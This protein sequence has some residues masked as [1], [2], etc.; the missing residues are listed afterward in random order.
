[1]TIK[2]YIQQKMSAFGKISD[3]DLIDTGLALDAEY[4]EDVTNEVGMALCSLIEERVLAPYVQNVS[5]SG[6]SMSWNMDNIGKYYLW[7]C[8]RYDKKPDGDVLSM[9]GV[10]LIKDVSNIW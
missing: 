5:E 4:T 3:A 2:Q 6:F 8:K 10:S 9:L 1:M 7:L